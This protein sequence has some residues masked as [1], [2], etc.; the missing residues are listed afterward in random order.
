MFIFNKLYYIIFNNY[1]FI[2]KLLT[3][4][5]EHDNFKKYKN[6]HL[7]YILEK[8]ILVLTNISMR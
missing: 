4:E 8:C 7:D 1:D 5:T 3:Y 6:H 2:E